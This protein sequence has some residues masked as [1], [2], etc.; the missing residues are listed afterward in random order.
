[1]KI[2]PKVCTLTKF[3]KLKNVVVIE[4]SHK[5]PFEWVKQEISQLN[6]TKNTQII[7]FCSF[8]LF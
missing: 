4:T 6:N 2:V 7:A 3:D 1:M 5:I 8:C